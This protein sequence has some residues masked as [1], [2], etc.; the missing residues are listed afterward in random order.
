MKKKFKIENLDCAHCAQKMED[1]INKI[2]GVEEASISFLTQKFTL[3]AD[4]AVMDEVLEKAKAEILKI[5]PD[6]K[7][8]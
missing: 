8:S 2:P 1:A 4:E 7:L 5:E 3:I 6:C